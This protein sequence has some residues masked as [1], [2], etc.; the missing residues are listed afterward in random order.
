NL[1]RNVGRPDHHHVAPGNHAV[2]ESEQ[3]GHHP[4]FHVPQH[5]SP[6]RGDGVDLVDKDY[7][8]SLAGGL[9]KDL[10]ELGLAFSVEL[11][12]NL[13]TVDLDEMEFDLAGDGPG[14]Q[15][16]ARSGR[17]IEEHALGDFDPQSFKNLGIVQGKFHH[18]PHQPEFFVQ[19]ADVFIGDLGGAVHQIIGFLEDKIGLRVDD[20]RAGRRGRLYPEETVTAAEKRDVDLVAQKHRVSLEHLA[21]MFQFGFLGQ[22]AIGFQEIEDNGGGGLAGNLPD[23]DRV[24]HLDLGIGPDQPVDL[25][26]LFFM[27]LAQGPG[28]PAYRLSFA[29]DFNEI[30]QDGAQGLDI[31][32]V[33]ASPTLADI[34]AG[35]FA[36]F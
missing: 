24:A 13:G 20:D 8:G 10:P 29:G 2:H 14:N 35:S 26:V 12:D 31:F 7:A 32:R 4:F 17:A 33:Q 5:V 21:E 6:F 11:M 36:D 15:G 34:I 19:A 16:F 27:A 23:L 3:L 25:D 30:S 22:G 18:L 1:L 9:L 28:D